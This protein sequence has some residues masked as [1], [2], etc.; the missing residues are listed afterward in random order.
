MNDTIIG[1]II[2]AILALI[3]TLGGTF[4]GIRASNKLVNYQLSELKEEVKKHNCLIDRMYKVENRVTV[5]EKIHDIDSKEK[6]K[7]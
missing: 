5:I 7:D 3:G 4:G 6:D 1:A 2:T